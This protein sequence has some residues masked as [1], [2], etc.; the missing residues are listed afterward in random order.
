VVLFGELG[1]TGRPG[2]L[3][4]GE[5][6]EFCDKYFARALDRRLVDGYITGWSSETPQ[7][8]WNKV[9]IQEG[10]CSSWKAGAAGCKN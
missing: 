4:H 7:N 5:M 8:P 3:L 9:R 1:R 2:R 6:A 10:G